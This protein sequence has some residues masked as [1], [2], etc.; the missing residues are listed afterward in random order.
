MSNMYNFAKAHG[1]AAGV[2]A[3]AFVVFF[4]VTALSAF[5]SSAEWHYNYNLDYSKTYQNNPYHNNYDHWYYGSYGDVNEPTCS[6]TLTY[7]D[8]NATRYHSSYNDMP[9]TLRWTSSYADSG[10][11][12]P[13]VGS[14]GRSGSKTVYPRGKQTYTMTVSGRWGSS[15][16][17]VTAVHPYAH[18]DWYKPVSYFTPTYVSPTYTYPTSVNYVALNQMPY[19]GIGDMT[20]TA[21]AWLS[22]VLAGAFAAGFLAIR[23]PVLRSVITRS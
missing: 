16:C 8:S 5:A 10:F 7:E 3:V 23:N 17:Q 13:D 1:V 21:L 20:T 18:M 14:V 9:A 19:T 12:T 4:A 2:V 22:I 11:I 6:M 15:T